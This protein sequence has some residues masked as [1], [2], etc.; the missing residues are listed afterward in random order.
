MRLLQKGSF[1]LALISLSAFLLT[2]ATAAPHCHDDTTCCEN[3]GIKCPPEGSPCS[4]GGGFLPP[5]RFPCGKSLTCV[6]FDFGFPAADG[7]NR[8]TCQKLSEEPPKCS[9]DFCSMNGA[10]AVCKPTEGLSKVAL[11]GAW[12]KRTD[13]F[14]GPDCGFV[15]L[16]ICEEDGPFGSDGLQYCSLCHLRS[17]SC[18]SNFKIFG[19]V[20][21]PY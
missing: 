19:P 15:C 18:S 16:Q 13:G 21:K 8:G 14:P 12:A 9:L 10:N 6:I 20:P 1:P 5:P 17:A 11:C 7:P 3:Y 2:F 4:T